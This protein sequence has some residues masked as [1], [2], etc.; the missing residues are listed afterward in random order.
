M[1]VLGAGDDALNCEKG[2]ISEKR[3]ILGVGGTS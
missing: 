3:A 1:G 2:G